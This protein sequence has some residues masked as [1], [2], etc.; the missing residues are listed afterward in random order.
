MHHADSDSTTPFLPSEKRWLWRPDSQTL[1]DLGIYDAVEPRTT[2]LRGESLEPHQEAFLRDV[3]R[4]SGTIGDESDP[5]MQ[6]FLAVV[7]D[8]LSEENKS[9]LYF[10]KEFADTLSRRRLKA[11]PE[12]VTIDKLVG[13]YRFQAKSKRAPVLEGYF[14]DPRVAH[15]GIITREMVEE[16]MREMALECDKPVLLPMTTID[17]AAIRIPSKQRSH[18]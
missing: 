18:G 1:R 3:A 16:K 9:R 8:L 15:E 12:G 17:D 5:R 7:Q 14:F 2:G 13:R 11:E 10:V 6:A 4:V